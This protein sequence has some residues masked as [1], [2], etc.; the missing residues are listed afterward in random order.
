MGCVLGSAEYNESP[1]NSAISFKAPM[2]TFNLYRNGT[3]AA[4]EVAFRGIKVQPFDCIFVRGKAPF[5]KLIMFMT[6]LTGAKARSKEHTRIEPN[7]FSHI[8]MVITSD[9]LDHPNV[10]PGKVYIWESTKGE[11]PS[12]DGRNE[13]ECQLRDLDA[14][15]RD[16]DHHN[17][18]TY[19]GEWSMAIGKLLPSLRAKLPQDPAERKK[20]FSEFFKE[21]NQA[22]YNTNAFDLLKSVNIVPD[23]DFLTKLSAR[24]AAAFCSQLQ[25]MTYEYMGLLP[26]DVDPVKALPMDFLGLDKEGEIPNMCE[27][28]WFIAGNRSEV[29]EDQ[30]K[31][32]AHPGF[33]AEPIT[34]ILSSVSVAA[35]PAAAAA[36]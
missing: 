33:T 16:V 36:K 20:R 19:K 4:D 13:N 22:P 11:V 8:G 5:S 12:V 17:K 3:G 32:R 25:C 21:F 10:K 31:A 35:S 24:K 2:S 23:S 30:E 9:V 1:A 18:K 29:H 6:E 26:E 15:L 34:R 7:D 27:E 28:P 14:V